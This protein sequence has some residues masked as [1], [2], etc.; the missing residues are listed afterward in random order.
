V[1]LAATGKNLAINLE[2]C[3]GTYA[4]QCDF[5]KT[6]MGIPKPIPMRDVFFAPAGDSIN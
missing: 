4:R 1:F 5:R 2:A 6:V 3:A